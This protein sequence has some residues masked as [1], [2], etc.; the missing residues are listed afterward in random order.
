M[1]RRFSARQRIKKLAH[2]LRHAIWMRMGTSYPV[3]VWQM[4][5]VGSRTIVDTLHEKGYPGAVYHVHVLSDTLVFDGEVYRRSKLL[6]NDEYLRNIALREFFEST[7]DRCWKIITLVRD[8]VARNVSAFFQNLSLYVPGVDGNENM[9]AFG[10]DRVIEIFFSE[11]DHDRPLVWF[12]EEIAGVAGIDVFKD[13]F[14]TVNG[15]KI[16]GDE[17]RTVLVIRLEDLERSGAEALSAYLDYPVDSLVVSNTAD[18]KGYRM[19]YREFLSRV[20]F[21]V[22]YLDR[23]YD[24]KF[25]RHFYTDTER[26]RMRQR[27]RVCN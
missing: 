15:F 12:D 24:S 22:D 2:R 10:V 6:G 19:L 7:Q 26:E 14:D 3:I 1:S 13:P 20:S 8:P 4:G 5:K 18:T 25:C 17:D 11:F 21:P 23:M 27:W 9:D 16:Y